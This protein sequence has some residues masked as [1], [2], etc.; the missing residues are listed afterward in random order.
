MAEMKR[1]MRKDFA[2]GP[3]DPPKRLPNGWL[4]CCARAARVGI[5]EYEGEDGKVVRELRIPEE[6]FKPEAMAS[7]AMVP[8]TNTHPPVLLD[9]KNAGS[10]SKGHTGQDIRQDGDW[11]IVPMM[12]T[13][14]KTIM[15]VETGGSG[16][17]NGYS[18]SLDSAQHPELTLKYGAYDFIQRDIIGNH[19]AVNVTPRA[20]PDA[21]VRL[22]SAGNA[23]LASAPPPATAPTQKGQKMATVKIDGLDLPVTDASVG[24][25]QAAHDKAVNAAA[26]KADAATSTA[27]ARADAAEKKVK[28]VLANAKALLDSRNRLRSIWDAVKAKM[29]GCDECGGSGRVPMA[30]DATKT[31]ACDYCDGTGSIRMHSP[32]MAKAG[33]A[34]DDDMEAEFEEGAD[35]DEDELAVEQQTEEEAGAAHKDSKKRLDAKKKTRATEAAEFAKARADSIDR[36]VSRRMDARRLLEGTARKFVPAETDLA[37]LDNKGVQIA[38]IKALAPTANMDGKTEAQIA[39]RYDMEIERAA[40][41]GT[42]E[43]KDS[44]TQTRV[45]PVNGSRADAW[46]NLNLDADDARTKMLDRQNKQPVA[47]A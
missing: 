20:G 23:L 21:R 27:N 29:I 16:V 19:L 45:I 17:S 41:T 25:L 1:V 30:D 39:S 4:M 13:D 43:H 31:A 11:L 46:S 35:M 32:I 37:K 6:V 3:I 12:I 26:T 14:E 28:I 22:D 10:Y 18:A 15:D 47:K 34:D 5:Q 24:T 9:A 44:A 42:T 2:D 33:E 38:V 8:V 7:F 36:M 40:E